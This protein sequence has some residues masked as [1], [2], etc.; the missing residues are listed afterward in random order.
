VVSDYPLQYAFDKYSTLSDALADTYTA[1]GHT[2]FLLTFP[3]ANAT[4]TW[5]NDSAKWTERLTWIS[6]D[7]RFVEWRP[8]WHAMAFGEHRMLDRETGAVYVMSNAI[9]TDVDGRPIRRVRRAP[10]LFSENQ[11]IFFS[12]F[13][14]LLDPGLGLKFPPGGG[15]IIQTGVN[16]VIDVT[17]GGG[18]L[19]F[20]V[21]VPPGLYYTPRQ[22]CLAIVTVC[23]ADTGITGW[24][25]TFGIGETSGSRL[26][27]RFTLGNTTTLFLITVDFGTGPNVA[28]SI[29]PTLG[30]AAA[31]FAGVETASGPPLFGSDG[32]VNGVDPQVMLRMSNDG[33]KTW[34]TEMMRSTGKIGEYGKRVRWDRLGRARRRVFEISTSDPVPYRITGATIQLGQGVKG[35]QQQA[36]AG[37]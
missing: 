27:A 37:A 9:S 30:F 2:F 17:A 34:G 7:S 21:R 23:E 28:I 10:C 11:P 25:C 33:G 4:W 20:V 6:E 18:A 13:E 3:T 1:D 19:S 24:V 5:D 26:S 16:D 35:A 31:D 32:A 8:Q 22:L 14:L 12:S 29:G 36:Q 15:I